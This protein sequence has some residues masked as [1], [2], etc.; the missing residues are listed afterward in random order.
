VDEKDKTYWEIRQEQKFLA[1]EKK[2]NAY[3]K[4]LE[5]SFEQSK[6]EIRKIIN[7][8]Y[9]RYADEN[10]V[11]FAAAQQMLHKEEIGELKDF[12]ALV[13]E[14]MGKYNQELNN[15]S[16]KARITRYKAM[17]K[18][19]DA[20]LQQ[21]YS[22]EYQYKGEELLKEVY[23]DSYYTTWFNIDQYHGF[24]AD[25]AQINPITVEELIKYPFNGANFSSRLWNQKDYMLKQLNE[26][27]TTML[28]QGKNPSTLSYDFAKKFD[29][30]K[31]E[32]Y[33]L[34]HTEGAFIMEPGTIEGRLVQ[35]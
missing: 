27:I 33:R 22:V 1:G 14:N 6:R 8:F 21:L 3:Y 17:E 29:V 25:F 9:G 7:D 2:V 20:L 28:I 11:S 10:K 4:G 12:I 30:R 34:L 32:A 15:I 5:K 19:I 24:H 26:S 13:N 35:E 18:Q 23:S 16:I 31:S